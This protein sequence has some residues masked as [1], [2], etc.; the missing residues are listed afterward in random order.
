MQSN[1]LVKLTCAALLAVLLGSVFVVAK[2]IIVPIFFAA[3]MAYVIAHTANRLS[4][5]PGLRWCPVWSLRLMTLVIFAI[6]LVV[7]FGVIVSTGQELLAR[8]PDYQANV[9]TLVQETFS[10]LGRSGPVD[11]GQI[12]EATFGQLD[13]RAAVLSLLSSL[14]SAGGTLFLILIY[15]FFLLSERGRFVGKIYAAATT[16]AQAQK[17][18]AVV[19]EINNQIANY[20][21]T[22]TSINLILGVMSY[23]ILLVLGVDFALFW[24]ILIALLNY[25]PY[26]GSMLGVALPVALS[27]A[28]FGSLQTTALVLASLLAAQLWVGNYLEPRLIGKQLNMSPLIILLSL[29]VFSALWGLAGAILA[30]PLTSIIAITLGAF[31]ETRFVAVLLAE[32]VEDS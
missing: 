25:I 19:A 3:I 22:K 31:D 1:T 8:L 18:L 30:V 17:I 27:I 11:W 15:A 24:A 5:V 21:G 10:L 7:F 28:Q 23:V 9:E 16:E 4:K 14:T 29:S 32:T 13:V 6:I 26:V 2:G 12:Y 20:L